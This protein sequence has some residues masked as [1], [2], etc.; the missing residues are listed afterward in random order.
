MYFEETLSRWHCPNCGEL[1]QGVKNE[2]GVAKGTCRK[3][4]SCMVRK[5]MGRRHDRVEIYAPKGQ[6]RIPAY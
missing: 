1:V 2:D 4:G 3:C 6:E 5:Y